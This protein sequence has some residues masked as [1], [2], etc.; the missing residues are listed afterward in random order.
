MLHVTCDIVGIAQYICI[1]FETQDGSLV[2]CTVSKFQAFP[3]CFAFENIT[4]RTKT[5]LLTL[6]YS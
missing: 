4:T 5:V 6:I 3:G 2:L 1:I